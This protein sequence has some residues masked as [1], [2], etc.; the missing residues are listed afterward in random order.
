ME[1][2]CPMETG[3][4]L[5]LPRS[6]ALKAKK[7]QFSFG[8]PPLQAVEVL[9]TLPGTYMDLR[10]DFTRMKEITVGTLLGFSAP[11]NLLTDSRHCWQ[12]HP[13]ILY[14]RCHF[15]SGFNPLS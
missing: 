6:L 10:L 15:V 3:L 11:R 4:T 13:C 9:Q 8:F 7:L 1:F 2:L 5:P 14:T 12:Q